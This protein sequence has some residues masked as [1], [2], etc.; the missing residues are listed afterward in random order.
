MEIFH[1]KES[2]QI[3]Y[4]SKRHKYHKFYASVKVKKENF[5]NDFQ[6]NSYESF[7]L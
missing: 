4:I 3:N 6:L 1:S 7:Q 2:L 5:Q